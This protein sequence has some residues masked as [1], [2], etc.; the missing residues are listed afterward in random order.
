MRY[1]EMW[2]SLMLDIPDFF[3]QSVLTLTPLPTRG[4][5]SKT[6]GDGLEHETEPMD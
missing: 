1:A 3:S 2:L 6:L 4:P 5:L